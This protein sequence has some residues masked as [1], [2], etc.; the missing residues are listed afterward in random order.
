MIGP[1]V[2]APVGPDVIQALQSVQVTTSS[3]QR[4]GFQITLAVSK[5]STLMTTMIPSGYFDPGIRVIIVVTMNGTANVLMDGLITRQELNISNDLGQSTLTITGEDLSVAMGFI[6]FNIPYPAMPMFARV[7]LILAKYAMF[8]IVPMPIPELIPDVASP[9]SQYA[10]SEGTDLAYIEAMAKKIGYVFF[11]EPGPVP[12]ASVAYWGPDIR[13][14][15]PQSAL[16]VNMDSQTNVES[17]S[18]TNDGMSR[19]QPY[20]LIQEPI[21]K[22]PIPIPIP[23]ITPLAPPLAAKPALALRVQQMKDMAKLTPFQAAA[24][25]LGAAAESADAIVGSGRLDVIRYGGVLKARGLVGVRGA[26]VAYDGLYY[27]K[28]VTHNIKQGE[29]RQAFSLTRGG[30][31]SLTN[32]VPT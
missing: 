5:R 32:S 14:G 15:V 23:P 6:D 28:S 3:G 2:A 22:I 11:V 29:Y 27:V 26:G 18:F 8:G 31:I 9:T 20:V 30:T 12:G 1:M 21:T 16:N 10:T 17:L 24:K 4:S 25:A 13:V 19:V 7:A